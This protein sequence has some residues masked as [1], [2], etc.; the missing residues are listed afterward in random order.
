V[1]PDTFI[2]NYVSEFGMYYI[3]GDNIANY[4]LN[5]DFNNSGEG[6]HSW[7]HDWYSETIKSSGLSWGYGRM[8]TE[9][10]GSLWF[11]TEDYGFD[12]DISD[13]YIRVPLSDNYFG[14]TVISQDH[15][16]FS[17]TGNA[18]EYDGVYY[19][20]TNSPVYIMTEFTVPAGESYLSFDL[21]MIDLNGGDM[22]ELWLNDFLFYSVYAD[23]FGMDDWQ[24]IFDI[25][26]SRWSGEDVLLSFGLIA[27][28]D[29]VHSQFGIR[30][31]RIYRNDSNTEA[32]PEPNTILLL[33]LGFIGLVVCRKKR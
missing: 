3:G 32:V 10:L 15:L 13:T 33:G 29:G 18:W 6:D 2:E 14:E 21:N 9:D 12:I 25:N 30:N 28:M 7:I 5:D 23:I 8:N 17:S 31:V 22:F 1:G 24:N 20:L 26:L 11:Q 4:G 19:A 16:N 27:E